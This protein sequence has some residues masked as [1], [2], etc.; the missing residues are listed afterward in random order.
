MFSIF[1]LGGLWNSKE[2]WVSENKWEEIGRHDIDVKISMRKW[3]DFNGQKNHPKEKKKIYNYSWV[4]WTL[5]AF[6]KMHDL[7]FHVYWMNFFQKIKK[8]KLESSFVSWEQK[9]GER[10]F[11]TILVNLIWTLPLAIDIL[12]GGSS[13]SIW[14][15]ATKTMYLVEQDSTVNNEILANLAIIKGIT[16]TVIPQC[17][18][19]HWYS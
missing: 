10:G 8:E 6:Q 16:N 13:H 18:L 4:S 2:C 15:F 3:L 5:A 1:E 19:K 12:H 9:S 17:K 7:N 14:S 11:T